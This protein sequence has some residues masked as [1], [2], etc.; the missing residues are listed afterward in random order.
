M[1]NG[2]LGSGHRSSGTPRLVLQSLT[3]SSGGCFSLVSS[4]CSRRRDAMPLD[5]SGNAAGAGRGWL[6][7]GIGRGRGMR[8]IET[9][10]AKPAAG[11]SRRGDDRRESGWLTAL[12]GTGASTGTGMDESRP[13]A[14]GGGA[15]GSEVGCAMIRRVTSQLP[16]PKL[17]S[18]R[19]E[20]SSMVL[21]LSLEREDMLG[22]VTSGAARGSGFRPADARWPAFGS[23]VSSRKMSISC[24]PVI[25][26]SNALLP[27]AGSV[28]P[29]EP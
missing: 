8:D 9:V 20:W 17:F 29:P 15:T 26:S 13:M 27:A 18:S 5:G 19:G 28:A 1:K 11:A 14:R 16:D 23:A 25:T 10:L 12:R 2:G 21:R 4:P 6:W 7:G 24:D 22:C 3:G